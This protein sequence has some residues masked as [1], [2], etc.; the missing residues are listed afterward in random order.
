MIRLQLGARFYWWRWLALAF[1]FLRLR[2]MR[3]VYDAD[4]G[5]GLV[6]PGAYAMCLSVCGGFEGDDGRKVTGDEVVRKTRV[7]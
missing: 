5:L 2:W 6:V 1:A 3:R 4:R 7:R